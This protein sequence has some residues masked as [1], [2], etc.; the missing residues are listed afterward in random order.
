MPAMASSPCSAVAIRSALPMCGISA[1]ISGTAAGLLLETA[2]TGPR[3]IAPWRGETDIF[4]RPGYEFRIADGLMTNFHLPKST[5]LM[6]VSAVM[7]V[8]RMR[9]I[10]AHAIA[11]R[12][13]FFSYGDSSLL[14]PRG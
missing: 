6:L 7:G 10:Y 3:R 4:I 12:Y 11:R 2:A 1:T 13:R 14:L 8:E 9:A 5:L